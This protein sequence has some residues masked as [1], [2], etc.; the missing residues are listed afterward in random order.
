MILG[1]AAYMA[2]EQ[3]RGRAVDKRADIWAFGVVLCEMLYGPPAL[4]GRH[5][6]DVLAAVLRQEIDWQPLP[7]D[8]PA[9]VRTLL[10]RCLDRDP[11]TRLRDIGEARVALSRGDELR[12]ANTAT[13]ASIPTRA[14]GRR[15]FGARESVAWGVALGRPRQRSGSGSPVRP[16][17]GRQMR[18]G[19]AVT[20]TFVPPDAIVS[21]A[22]GTLISPDGQKLLFTGRAADGSRSLWIRRLDTLAVT[23]LPDTQDAIEPFWSP[24]SRAIAFGAQGKLKRLDLGAARAQVLTDAARS[25]NGAWSPAGVIV[26]SPDY[27]QPLARVA[28]TG[29]ERTP[30]TVLDRTAGDMG[31]RYPSFLPDGRHFLYTAGR[32]GT[33]AVM[34]GSTDSTDV[35]QVLLNVGAAIYA[36]PGWLLYVVNG[37]A[38]AQP[39]DADRLE[40]SGR[41]EPIADITVR[42]AV[43]QGTRLSVSDTGTLVIQDAPT[44]EYSLMWYRR[45]GK[46]VST[47]GPI[48]RVSVAEFPRISPDGTRVVVQRFDYATQN[49]DLWIGDLERGTFDRLTTN[50]AQEQ[51]AFWAPDGKSVF[52]TTWR[53]GRNGIFRI[54]IDGSPEQLL[55]PG[56]VFPAHLSPDRKTFFYFLRG[57]TTRSDIWAMPYVERGLAPGADAS[58]ARPILNSEADELHGQVSPDGNWLAYMSDVAGVAEI[59]VRRLESEGRV[60]TESTRVTTAGGV[61][62]CWSRD[63]RELFY[64]SAPKDYERRR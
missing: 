41:P 13:P 58:G 26:F 31:H 25:N 51:L 14:I 37:V 24:D 18:R 44:Y 9:R 57:A 42:G 60:S 5:V 46:S 21:E 17:P 22:S 50:S 35:R 19:Q 29:G 27:R 39:F 48:R 3:A 33:M 2:P 40:L 15:G 23:P 8:T 4:R 54:P 43:P 36:K 32:D 30:V 62:P 52:A 1:T 53:S 61:Q 38:V 6:P 49:Q 34:V 12:P 47:F 55:V 59:Y 64:V 7:A 28:A 56:T 63:G 11:K 45:D 16:L 10:E 20:L